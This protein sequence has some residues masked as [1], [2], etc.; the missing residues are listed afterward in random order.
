MN[1][2]YLII[3]IAL[4]IISI[5]LSVIFNRKG[6]GLQENGLPFAL[7]ILLEN[8]G[9]IE[10]IESVDSSRS[11]VSFKLKD[12]EK[13]NIE[14]INELGASG[15]VETSSGVSLIFGDIS[16]TICDLVKVKL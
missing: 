6:K 13:I 11:K 16:Q 10:N 1:Q 15:I 7:E 9:G 2:T 14:K 8:L 3:G 5:I 4:V 12:N